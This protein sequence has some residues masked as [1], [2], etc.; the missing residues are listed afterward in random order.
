M[1]VTYLHLCDYAFL[2]DNGKI[3]VIGIF[4]RI[5]SKQFPTTHNTMFV[6]GQVTEIRQEET[7]TLVICKGKREVF[8]Q[9]FIQ[10]LQSHVSPVRSYNFL[11]GLHNFTFTDHGVYDVIVR[12]GEKEIGSTK[13]VLEKTAEGN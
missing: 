2:T 11:I 7:L 5:Y 4:D 10:N 9:Q 12:N 8:N 3:G 1:T 13:L 6:V